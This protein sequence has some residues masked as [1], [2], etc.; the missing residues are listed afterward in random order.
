VRL[1][2][3]AALLACVVAALARLEVLAADDALDSWPAWLLAGSGALLG[4]AFLAYLLERLA[5]L[6]VS[7]ARCRDCRK[8]IPYG[9]FYCYDHLRDRTEAAKEK[10]HGERGLGV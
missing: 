8:R 10:Y 2:L 4:V 7:G 5:G 3:L 6:P 9:R 1:A